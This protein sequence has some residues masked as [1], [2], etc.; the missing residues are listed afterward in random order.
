MI[1]K[2]LIDYYKTLIDL[3]NAINKNTIPKNENPEKADN[4]VEKILGF[5]K[6]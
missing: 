4:P 2:A 3:R 5:K 1:I 6:Q